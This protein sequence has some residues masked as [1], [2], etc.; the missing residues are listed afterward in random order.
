[1][2]N[3][4]RFQRI[5]D[6]VDIVKVEVSELR[7]DFKVHMIKIEEHVAG[8]KKIINELTPV[9]AK[10]PDIVK[11]AEEYQFSQQLKK[12][13]YKTLGIAATVIGVIVGIFKVL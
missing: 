1:M 5:E 6:K 8:D 10:L 7:A 3:E 9:L 13:A 12:R 4:S 11:M 2:S